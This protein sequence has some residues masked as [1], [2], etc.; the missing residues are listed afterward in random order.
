M[1]SI[2][3]DRQSM[4]A[5]CRLA[6]GRREDGFGMA[7]GLVLML[8]GLGGGPCVAEGP[9][10]PSAT[11]SERP[12]RNQAT[13]SDLENVAITPRIGQMVPQNVEFLDSSGKPV[14]LQDCLGARP[15][16]LT[17]VY[18][19]C[20]MLCGLELNGL[21]SCLRAMDLTAG[22]DFDIV[23]FSID[24]RET[25][26]LAA[27]KKAGYVH[28]YGREIPAEGWR[29]LTGHADAI[30]QLCES[31]GFQAVYDPESGQYAHAAGVMVLT[32]DGQISR[33]FYGVE[34]QPRDVRLAMIEASQGKLGTAS[35]QVLLY[36]YAYDPTTGKYGLA[37]MNLIRAGGVLTLIV[38]AAVIGRM[39]WHERSHPGDGVRRQEASETAQPGQEHFDE[40][41]PDAT[42]VGRETT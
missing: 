33:Y 32:P 34:F 10:A 24:P 20:P 12:V 38:M 41:H 11:G 7:L 27:E 3:Q 17:P 35:D 42:R 26:S 2:G 19:R 31:V 4:S 37:I 28:A 23:T 22:E 40:R 9:D 15:V 1:I 8:A 6:S 13:A 36:C 5:C 21:V 16:L 30:Q 14:T 18:Y 39:L 29:F 25:P